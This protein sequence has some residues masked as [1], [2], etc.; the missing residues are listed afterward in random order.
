MRAAILFLLDQQPNDDHAM[1]RFY[2]TVFCWG[3]FSVF[4][5]A[6]VTLDD[7]VLKGMRERIGRGGGGK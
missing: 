4:G 7:Q 2:N 5:C 6:D 3:A 1:N